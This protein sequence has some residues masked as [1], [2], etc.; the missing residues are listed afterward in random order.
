VTV[1][2]QDFSEEVCGVDEARK[3]DKTEK[4]LTGPLLNPV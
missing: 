1:N 4:V 2:R 3:E